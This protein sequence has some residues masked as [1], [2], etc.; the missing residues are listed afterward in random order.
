M[1]QQLTS[2]V[3][4]SINGQSTGGPGPGPGGGV[5]GGN[6]NNQMMGGFQ[7]H[8]T[9]GMGNDMTGMSGHHVDGI[10]GGLDPC[11]MGS[12]MPGIG[13]FGMHGSNNPNLSLGMMG[14]PG[15]RSLSPKLGGGIVGFPTGGPVGMPHRMIGRPSMGGSPYNGANIQVKA[16]TPNTIQYLPARP[17][18]GNANPRAPPSLDFLQRFANPMSSMDG[19]NKVPGGQNMNFYPNC[20]QMGQNGPTSL[21]MNSHMDGGGNMGGGDGS[22]MLNIGGMTGPSGPMMGQNLMMRGL[23][24]PGQGGMVRLQGPP[25]MSGTTGAAGTGTGG[26]HHHH[27]HHHHPFNSGPPNGPNDPSMFPNNQM[28]AAGSKG[29]PM[30]VGGGPPGTGQNPHPSQM[31]GA[32]PGGAPDASQPL[33]PSMGG[34]GQ[35]GPGGVGG[36]T[37]AVSGNNFKSSQFVGPSTTDPN[38]AQQ[39]HNFQQ[40]LYATS[41]RSHMN[42]HPG[43]GAL[44]GG[45]TNPNQ[46]F[47]VPK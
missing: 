44:T 36:G 33:P 39:Y 6:P 41:T 29:S 17:Q 19:G 2:S 21:G 13:Q 5:V 3:S 10:M 12:V 47:F 14:G 9:M 7:N 45:P 24:P 28:F 22:G 30:N 31:T 18:V 32:G 27:H 42:N 11:G 23:R 15:P 43:A 40:Q 37:Q 8:G 26:L 4:N 46:S 16:S 38:Y 35:T 20:N 34:V 25:H 1:S